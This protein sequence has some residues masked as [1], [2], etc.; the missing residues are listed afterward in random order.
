MHDCLVASLILNRPVR[1]HQLFDWPV[2]LRQLSDWPVR[3]LQ[4]SDRPVRYFLCNFVG[5]D[6][7]FQFWCHSINGRSFVSVCTRYCTNIHCLH[8]LVLIF[9]NSW[10]WLSCDQM[11]VIQTEIK[12]DWPRPIV[13]VVTWLFV[14]S[15]SWFLG[16]KKLS[17]FFFPKLV[18]VSVYDMTKQNLHSVHAACYLPWREPRP[19][20]IMDTISLTCHSCWQS[21][22]TTFYNYT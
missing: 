3:L 14:C 7:T 10:I 9:H 18:Q 16:M 6:C 5:E 15:P 12:P 20:L 13:V 8:L 19:V 21:E 4:L 17:T 22:S 1:L 2:R 11:V